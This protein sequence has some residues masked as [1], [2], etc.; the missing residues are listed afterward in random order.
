[1]TPRTAH[2]WEEIPCFA[3][4]YDGCSRCACVLV[5][6]SMLL[7]VWL[8]SL[9]GGPVS[10]IL[11]ERQTPERRAALEAALGLDEPICRPVPEVHGARAPGHFG[12]STKVLPGEDASRS[13]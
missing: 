10:A 2:A 13:S 5:V 12:I 3:S 11:G 7:F 1:M 9:P 8:R 6:L 4:S